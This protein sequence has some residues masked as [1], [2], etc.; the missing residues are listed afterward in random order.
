MIFSL[1]PR[2]QR[3]AL[4][5][6]I[7]FLLSTAH[8][9]TPGQ[10][11][12]GATYA[13]IARNLALDPGSAF[14]LFYSPSLYP[15]FIEHPPLHFWLQAFFFHVCG[16]HWWTEDVYGAIFWMIT[17]LGIDRLGRWSG[18]SKRALQWA[19]ILWTAIPIVAWTFGNNLLEITLSAFTVWSAATMIYGMRRGKYIYLPLG[20]LWIAAAF[21]TKGPVGLFPLAIPFF[22]H[23]TGNAPNSTWKRNVIDSLLVLLGLVIPLGLSLLYA[24]SAQYLEAYWQK[25]IIHSLT[26]VVTV[27]SRWY[28][29]ANFMMQLILPAIIALGVRKFRPI[30]EGRRALSPRTL[31]FAFIALSAVLPMMISWKQRDF[32]AVPAYPFAAMALAFVLDGHKTAGKALHPRILWQWTI[33]LWL[34]GLALRSLPEVHT[35][36]DFTLRKSIFQVAKM[37]R[38][39]TFHVSDS[40]YQDWNVHA[41]CARVGQI[42]LSEQKG[43][44]DHDFWE[45]HLV[46]DRVQVRKPYYR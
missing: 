32:Y 19:L 43:D 46:Q 38:G 21:F 9:F 10:F 45:L 4:A 20:G 7:F 34:F 17:A 3:I 36:R 15:N 39:E 12:D 31:A 8:L 5:G 22:W 28:L 37:H 44:K 33:G 42:Y 25:Q 18:L 2:I 29:P 24:P 16:D 11:I 23:L 6:G 1:R 26:S 40:L 41:Q 13:A 35:S 27:E 30:A 14:T